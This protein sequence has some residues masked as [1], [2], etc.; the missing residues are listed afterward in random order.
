MPWLGIWGQRFPTASGHHILCLICA[1]EEPV[2]RKPRWTVLSPR[3]A[4][5]GVTPVIG[6]GSCSDHRWI[7]RGKGPRTQV[8]LAVSMGPAGQG[9]RAQGLSA[10]GPGVTSGN[11][12]QQEQARLS[13]SGHSQCLRTTR[14]EL[15][16]RPV[17][18]SGGGP[19]GCHGESKGTALG[20]PGWGAHLLLALD[21]LGWR[22]L[23][24]GKDT[25]CAQ[26]TI[27]GKQST[28]R[29]NESMSEQV[30]E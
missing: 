22:H 3:L 23:K 1:T 10:L 13:Q 15:D 8:R 5:A 30:S 24:E 4:G 9:F 7:T 21:L 6:H 14:L 2:K 29:M 28:H 12:Q 27:T 17:D 16:P 25:L 18:C 26:C 11:L 20:A 19:W